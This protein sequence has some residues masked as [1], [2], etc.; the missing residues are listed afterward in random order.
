MGVPEVLGIPVRSRILRRWREWFAPETQ[1]F[2]DRLAEFGGC[3]CRSRQSIRADRGVAGHVLHVW[4][5]VDMV[6][7]GCLLGAPTE[8]SASLL[9]VRRRTVRPKSMPVWPSKLAAAGEELMLHWI[10]SGVR[11]SR[12]QAVPP[13]V[14][15]RAAPSTPEGPA[16][17]WKLLLHRVR[18]IL[19]WHRHGSVGSLQRQIFRVVREP[20]QTWLNRHTEPIEG[21]YVIPNRASFSCGRSMA[22]WPTRP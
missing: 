22:I 19:L 5:D 16:A 18:A 21:T 6:G 2:P 8:S 3:G 15:N 9:A 20:F 13:E 10:A 4:R 7:R 11:T 12:H 1:P 14:W 17:G